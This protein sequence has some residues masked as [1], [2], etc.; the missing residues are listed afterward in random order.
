MPALPMPEDDMP[1]MGEGQMPM[2][3][4]DE[5]A[6][7]EESSEEFR[8]LLVQRISKL[9]SEEKQ[10][11]D[12]LITPE[13]ADILSRVLPELGDI[14]ERVAGGGA[15]PMAAGDGALGALG[16][17]PLP[18]EEEDEASYEKLA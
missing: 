12:K 5:G 13:I 7:A 17:S 9:S 14:I 15:P 16:A 18:A 3:A 10:Q 2:G 4:E 6:E 1:M 8:E 11:L